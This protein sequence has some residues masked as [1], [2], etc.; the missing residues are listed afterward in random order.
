MSY[1]AKRNKLL[2]A[3]KKDAFHTADELADYIAEIL[4]CPITIED[5]NHHLISYSKHTDKIDE[6]RISTIIQRKVPD[7]VING[8]WKSGVMTKLFEGDDPVVIPAIPTVGLG[9]RVAVSVRKNNE[10]L[11]FIWAH[12]N[13]KTLLDDELL[14]L[15]EAAKQVKNYIV[16]NNLRKQNSAAGYKDFFWQLMLGNINDE[17]KILQLAKRYDMDLKGRMAVAIIQFNSAVSKTVEKHANYLAD[18]LYHVQVV[19]RLFDDQ[20]L[21][22]LVR[23]KKDTDTTKK[24]N[25]YIQ[26]FIEEIGNRLEIDDIIGGSGLIYQSPLDIRHSY[27]QAEKVLLMKQKFPAELRNVY[28][29][30]NLG[31]HQFL[32]DLYRLR[33]NENYKNEIIEK[34]KAYDIK[35]RT[36]L[37][38]SLKVYLEADSNVYQAAK[39]IHVH[40]NTMN[41]RL[42]RISE[43][44]GID[45][46]DPNQKITVYLDLLLDN[47]ISK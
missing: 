35:H 44:G 42:K 19:C 23:M 38:S 3:N 4:E 24:L 33:K 21:L 22:L 39:E 5:S 40:P 17:Q 43:I 1:S 41:Y 15:K 26:S 20:Q 28:T 7:K 32:D 8:L 45:L 31:I 30:Q 47:L 11:G 36:E 25:N 13:E 12:T 10:I 18:T 2:A 29:Y 37:L 46:K 14:L 34:L 6:A 16:Q 9:N 27:K